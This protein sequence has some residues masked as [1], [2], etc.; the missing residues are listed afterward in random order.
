ML[1]ALVLVYGFPGVGKSTVAPKIAD[2][3]GVP[4][5]AKDTI[6]EAMW[7][8]LRRPAL[9]PP[10]AWSRRLGAAAY[11]AMFRAATDLGPR[12]MIEA[13]LD[14]ERHRA[15]L[16]ELTPSPIEIFLFADADLVYDRHRERLP[17]QHACHK[18]HPLPTRRRVAAGLEATRPL[19]L[20]GPL[21]EVDLSE[22]CDVDAVSAWVRQHL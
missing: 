18:P 5:L 15:T 11:E 4:R 9:L 6:K 7:D 3:L 16:L 22:P 12:L 10:L 13:P 19:R 1:D 2:Q 14:P 17:R 21:L 8:A 20:G